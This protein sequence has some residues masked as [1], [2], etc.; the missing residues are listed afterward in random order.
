MNSILHI[1]NKI[2][3]EGTSPKEWEIS[4]IVPIFKKGDS[5]NPN[6]YRGIALIDTMQKLFCKI[7]AKRIQTACIQKNKWAL[8]KLENVVASSQLF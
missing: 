8:W 2:L 1:F 7:I 5:T 6:N 4:T 3:N